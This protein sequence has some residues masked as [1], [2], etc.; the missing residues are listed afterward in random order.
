MAVILAVIMGVLCLAIACAFLPRRWAWLGLAMCTLGAGLLWLDL[1]V[2]PM[3]D[4]DDFG[5]GAFFI[6]SWMVVGTVA[7]VVI[8]LREAAAPGRQRQAGEA[9]PLGLWPGPVGVLIGV[10]FMHW[11]SNRLAG[12]PPLM[13][14]LMTGAAGVAL[15]GGAGWLAWRA[16]LR[17]GFLRDLGHLAVAIGLTISAWVLV[18]AMDAE[19]TAALAGE[20]A[21]GAPWC[22]VTFAGHDRPRPAVDALELSRLV[23]RSGGRH[24]LDD[25]HWLVVEAP[26][27]MV[28]KRLRSGLSGP[29]KFDDLKIEGEAPPCTPQIGGNLDSGRKRP[30]YPPLTVKRG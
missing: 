5:F 18:S 25:A 2:Q 30:P 28:A 15:A 19:R 20:T 27:G 14:H 11:L 3:L 16:R 23:S 24:F 1:H 17:W 22:A 26:D 6:Q 13:A 29:A 7:L 12:A 9:P 4:G 8:V 21:E 10:F